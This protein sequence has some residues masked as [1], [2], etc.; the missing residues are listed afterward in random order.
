MRIKIRFS[1]QSIPHSPYK[2]ISWNPFFS[3][4]VNHAIVQTPTSNDD[5][6]ANNEYKE[7]NRL[8]HYYFCRGGGRTNQRSVCKWGA[9]R[10]KEQV[11]QRK[12]S[13]V[14]SAAE[15]WI[16][17]LD[18]AGFNV[19]AWQYSRKF[20]LVFFLR[21]RQIQEGTSSLRIIYESGLHRRGHAVA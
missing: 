6:L 5:L 14:T 9:T 11:S 12:H 21:F 19:G 7:K 18:E 17:I 16:T 1:R 8:S 2:H 4:E 15:P 20:S 3:W 13:T 10:N